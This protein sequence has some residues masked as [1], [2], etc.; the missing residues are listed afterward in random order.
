MF[1]V[2]GFLDRIKR[3]DTDC[4][5]SL[6]LRQGYFE[7]LLREFNLSNANLERIRAGSTEKSRERC[8]NE[9]HFG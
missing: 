1:R 7:S 9:L 3:T 2:G 5:I 4:G 8:R 6:V